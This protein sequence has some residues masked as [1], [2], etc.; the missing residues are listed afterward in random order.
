MAAKRLLGTV[1]TLICTLSTA[2]WTAPADA[3]SGHN[4]CQGATLPVT[5]P[6]DPTTY[7]VYGE[8]CWRGALAGQTVQLL[9]S[10]ITYDHNYWDFPFRPSRYSYVRRAVDAGYITFNIDRLG[11]GLSDHPPADPLTVPAEAYVNHQIIQALRHGDLAGT[12]FPRVVAVGH[13][14]GSAVSIYEA[15]TYADVD[16]VIV[17]GFLHAL[18]PDSNNGFLAIIYPA[19]ADPKFATAGLPPGYL[20]TRPGGR[21]FFYNT[22]YARPTVIATDEQLKQTTTS[23][24]LTTFGLGFDPK[25]S[26]HIHVPVLVVVGQRDFSFCNESLPGFS[27]ANSAAVFARE[28]FAYAPQSCLETYVLANSGHDINLHPDAHLWFEQANDWADRRVGTSQPPCQP[29]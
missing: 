13:S 5:L 24:E 22:A 3:H 29:C 23:G 18:N 2:L 1:T 12:A 10:G 20:T 11:V 8:L 16:G 15:G 27:C 7:H 17:T 28:S 4:Q 9:S 21:A 19:S 26:Q 25:L 14:F 6:N